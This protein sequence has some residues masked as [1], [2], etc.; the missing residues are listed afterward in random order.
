MAHLCN[1][2][3]VIFREGT[4]NEIV[5]GL[6]FKNSLE[7]VSCTNQYQNMKT[8]RNLDIVRNIGNIMKQTH[9]LLKLFV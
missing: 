9:R 1:L 3:R 5:F 6:F 4:V 2:I 8:E 7:L